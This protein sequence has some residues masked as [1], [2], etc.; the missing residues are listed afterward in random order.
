MFTISK[1]TDTKLKFLEPRRFNTKTKETIPQFGGSWNKASRI[2]SSTKPN[3]TKRKTARVKC[4][5]C[6]TNRTKD[7][8]GYK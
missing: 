3:R 7:A 4:I 1:G 6:K 2:L 8:K 5:S